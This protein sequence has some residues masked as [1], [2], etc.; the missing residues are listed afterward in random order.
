[1]AC[2][3]R[4]VLTA[5]CLWGSPAARSCPAR[6]GHTHVA[7]KSRHMF[8]TGAAWLG[9]ALQQRVLALQGA[10]AHVQHVR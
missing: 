2:E 5:N 7:C 8:M 6:G 3:V 4:Q 9:L 1:M 10:V